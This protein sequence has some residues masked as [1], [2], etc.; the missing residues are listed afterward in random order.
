[1]VYS[2]VVQY[3]CTV[4]VYSMG[5]Q[6]GLHC[7]LQCECTMW[8]YSMGVQCRSIVMVYSVVFRMGVQFWCT[9][10]FFSVGAN[11]E[12]FKNKLD[13]SEKPA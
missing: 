9:V 11:M 12:F 10:W 13:N 7:G 6:N 3:W 1:M 5:V 2:V 4:K 8:V